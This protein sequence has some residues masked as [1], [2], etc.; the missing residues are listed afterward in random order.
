MYAFQAIHFAL[1]MTKEI[2]QFLSATPFRKWRKTINQVLTPIRATR[3]KTEVNEL[4]AIINE[5]LKNFNNIKPK[6]KNNKNKSANK[7]LNE[8]IEAFR[9]MSVSSDGSDNDTASTY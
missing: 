3:I 4:H 5:A 8:E 6:Q 7:P 2:T 9:Q 1:F